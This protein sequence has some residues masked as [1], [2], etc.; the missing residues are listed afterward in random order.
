MAVR[1]IDLAEFSLDEVSSLLPVDWWLV[2]DTVR[3]S[4]RVERMVY[5]LSHKTA[6]GMEKSG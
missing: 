4:R 3:T 6:F 1:Y 5:I 2:R